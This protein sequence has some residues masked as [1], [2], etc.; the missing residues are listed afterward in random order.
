M[1]YRA[2]DQRCL[3]LK[4]HEQEKVH[5]GKYGVIGGKLEWSDINLAQPE[6]VN[7]EVLDYPNIFEKLLAREAFEEAGVTIQPQL[8][9]LSHMVFVRP[10]GIPVAFFKFAGQYA[11]GEVV[12]EAKAFS[13]FA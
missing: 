12:V 9:Y 7:G 4:R 11:S 2:S 8:H 1:V 10:D 5:P 13:D 3:I 6:H